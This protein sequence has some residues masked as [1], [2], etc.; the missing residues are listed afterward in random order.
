MMVASHGRESGGI[1]QRF[2]L[3]IQCV[4]RGFYLGICVIACSS[5]GFLCI[6]SH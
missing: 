5:E 1:F 2:L 4:G 6:Q 3:R